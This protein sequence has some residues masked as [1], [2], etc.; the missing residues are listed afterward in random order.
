MAVAPPKATKPKAPEQEPLTLKPEP[1][2][3]ELRGF[4][5]FMQREILRNPA[6]RQDRS[7]E[8]F[9]DAITAAMVYCGKR[10]WNTA[11]DMEEELEAQVAATL[12]VPVGHVSAEYV[13]RNNETKQPR[14]LFLTDWGFR[15][16]VE[17]QLNFTL[18]FKPVREAK[19]GSGNG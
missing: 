11:V 13:A 14:I 10:S 4:S 18:H 1:R 19:E 6:Y 8:G 5:A 7:W 17:G 12:R 16:A 2:K 9:I 3:H 15:E